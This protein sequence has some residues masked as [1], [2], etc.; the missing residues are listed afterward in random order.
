MAFSGNNGNKI[1]LL[2]GTS[3]FKFTLSIGHGNSVSPWWSETKDLA[4]IFADAITKN[5][6]LATYVRKRTAVFKHWNEQKFLSIISLNQPV[7]VY[8]GDI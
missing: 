2:A 3:L 7:Y 4:G 6:C 5:E 8:E 1:L